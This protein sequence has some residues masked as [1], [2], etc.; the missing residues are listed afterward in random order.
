MNVLLPKTVA[1]CRDI[2]ILAVVCPAWLA[3][4]GVPDAGTACVGV[5]GAFDLKGGG[6]EAPEE[7]GRKGHGLGGRELGGEL[8]RP[9]YKH[10]IH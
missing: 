7:M 8:R 9:V 5:G 10:R 2:A 4:E 3:G 6:G 1:V